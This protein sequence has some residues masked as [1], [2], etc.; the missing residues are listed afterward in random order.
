LQLVKRVP[1]FYGTWRFITAFTS[2]RHVCL[3]WA[4]SIWSIPP[5][6]TSWRSIL[7]LSS[8][9]WLGLPSGL[10]PLGFPTKTLYT[11]LPSTVQATCPAHLFSIYHS[12]NRLPVH[13]FQ[14]KFICWDMTVLFI[15]VSVKLRCDLLCCPN[16]AVGWWKVVVH[17]WNIC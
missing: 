3:S 12:H 2:A 9:L 4:S 7:I 5:Q 6:P 14:H 13:T 10:F 16:C 11:P 15:A 1:S 17:S 8:H